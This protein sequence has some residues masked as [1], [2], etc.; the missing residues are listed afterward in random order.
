MCK[1][2]PKMMDQNG[3]TTIELILL[4]VLVAFLA[5]IAYPIWVNF[6]TQTSIETNHNIAERLSTAVFQIYQLWTLNKNSSIVTLNNNSVLHVNPKGWPDGVGKEAEP[7]DEGCAKIWNILLKDQSP[8]MAGKD[9]C[10]T[11]V[12]CYN[13]IYAVGPP[14]TCTYR[15]NRMP[16]VGIVYIIKGTH[17]GLVSS[18][19]Q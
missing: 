7:T 9:G 18:F 19:S 4:L 13:A 6:R 1:L 10:D 12:S 16:S 3:F 14:I 2:N 15:I 5:V 17:A 8:A 11:N